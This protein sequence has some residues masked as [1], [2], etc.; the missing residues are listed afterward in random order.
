MGST[1]V[2]YLAAEVEATVPVTPE[3]APAVSSSSSG[4]E[5]AA[6]SSQQPSPDEVEYD[7]D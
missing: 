1:V 6:S 2:V 4:Q 7:T 3:E 5:E